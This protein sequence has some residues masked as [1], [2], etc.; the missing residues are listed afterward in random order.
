MKKIATILM[1]I[2][3]ILVGGMTL[4]AKTIKK[5][6][7]KSS[8]TAT[9][10]GDIPSAGII[11]AWRNYESQLINHG[12]RA[13]GS[14]CTKPGVCSFEHMG[15]SGGWVIDIEIPDSNKR[16]WLYNNIKSYIRNSKDKDIRK[17]TVR[18]YS[19]GIGWD[20]N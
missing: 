20:I 14:G 17:S 19:T 11:I 1:L 18:M 16:T 10:N 7:S 13:D 8:T 4:D 6:S 12:Y 9:W 5:K 2:T 15:T 3:A